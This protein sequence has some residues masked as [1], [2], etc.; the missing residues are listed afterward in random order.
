MSESESYLDPELPPT[1]PIADRQGNALAVPQ[2]RQPSPWRK[3]WRLLLPAV[4]CMAGSTIL[5]AIWLL[6][7]RAQQQPIVKATPELPLLR[8]QDAAEATPA[9]IYAEQRT[10]L[11]NEDPNHLGMFHRVIQGEARR[12]DVAIR[13]LLIDPESPCSQRPDDFSH[14]LDVLEREIGKKLLATTTRD[15]LADPTVY[16][17]RA[18]LLTKYQALQQ[19]RMGAIGRT[20]DMIY[21]FVGMA[22][23]WR[24]SRLIS[25]EILSESVARYQQEQDHDYEP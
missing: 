1:E 4:F 11:F 13:E 14:C 21:S 20:P 15:A 3:H 24:N 23:N 2:K 22:E 7:Q 5:G 8:A 9:Q 16:Q 12:L 25:S 19:V 17:D 10:M 18:A 6:P